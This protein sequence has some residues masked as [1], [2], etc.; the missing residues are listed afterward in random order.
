MKNF[1]KKPLLILTISSI[2]LSAMD[3]PVNP[4]HKGDVS[5][6]LFM[7][8]IKENTNEYKLV[9]KIE[10]DP[11][12]YFISE[13]ENSDLEI[14]NIQSQIK[15]GGQYY[16]QLYDELD[17]GDIIFAFSQVESRT[18]QQVIFDNNSSRGMVEIFLNG[19]FIKEID[20]QREKDRGHTEKG[21][22]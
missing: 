10:K 20:N 12:N 16:Y 3:I 19:T 17:K 8:P 9:G 11:M 13:S 14:K 5:N 2:Y 4:V 18:K 6:W 7:G 15:F 22:K 1:Y 21:F